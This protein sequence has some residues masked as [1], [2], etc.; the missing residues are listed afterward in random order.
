MIAEDDLI[1]NANMLLT[2]KIDFL[3]M[4]QKQLQNMD[5]NVR[6]KTSIVVL[7][8]MN[9]FDKKLIKDIEELT[10]EFGKKVNSNMH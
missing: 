4:L 7:C 2:D 1:K 10:I 5:E 6:I 9:Y 3:K 8:I